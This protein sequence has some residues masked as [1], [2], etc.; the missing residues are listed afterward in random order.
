[1][2]TSVPVCSEE[3]GLT[4][5]TIYIIEIFRQNWS[6]FPVFSPK[7]SF[8]K[9]SQTSM[10]SAHSYC[11]SAD[12]LLCPLVSTLWFHF[13]Q[14]TERNSNLPGSNFHQAVLAQHLSYLAKPPRD[15]SHC[16]NKTEKDKGLQ[17]LNSAFQK[18]GHKPN[19][20]EREMQSVLC[21]P[22]QEML[23]YYLLPSSSP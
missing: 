7:P 3:K 4:I 12:E 22:R 20:T 14:E 13:I 18:K 17:T 5:S 16:Y 8:L 21:R 15:N 10:K 9:K 2:Y 23:Q 1:M 11:R 19:T 6:S